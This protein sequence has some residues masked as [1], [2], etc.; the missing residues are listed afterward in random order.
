[1]SL[2]KSLAFRVVISLAG[3]VLASHTAA[4]QYSRSGSSSS[5]YATAP[6]RAPSSN[7]SAAPQNRLSSGSVYTG[8][9]VAHTTPIT[10]GSTAYK[11]V[12]YVQPS[13]SSISSAPRSTTSAPARTLPLVS[14]SGATTAVQQKSTTPSATAR[15]TTNQASQVAP[16]FHPG[17]SVVLLPGTILQG[18]S[19]AQTTPMTAPGSIP[20]ASSSRPNFGLVASRSAPTSSTGL[21]APHSSAANQSA[22]IT[23]AQS[24]QQPSRGASIGGTLL[25]ASPHTT[26]LS[27][28]P[29]F[30]TSQTTPQNVATSLPQ[31]AR[32]A[33][34]ATMGYIGES[35][36][37]AAKSAAQQTASGYRQATDPRANVVT[38]LEGSAAM[39]AG[40]INAVASPLAPIT[41]PVGSA[42]TY[43]GDKIGDNTT[44]QRFANSGPGV[45]VAR[46]TQDA[47]NLNTV[48]GAAAG[49]DNLTA[50]SRGTSAVPA[51]RAAQPVASTAGAARALIGADA[52]GQFLTTVG[53]GSGNFGLGS[54]TASDAATLGRAFVGPNARLASDG[55]TLVS[56]DGLRQY[57]PPTF[58]PN[59]GIVQAN[60][61]SRK[62]PN[63][64]WLDNGHLDVIQ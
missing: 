33:G 46:V 45:A 21:S 38:L 50:I 25:D 27:S 47:A 15:P 43:V 5:T 40:A 57:R 6:S 36:Q 10:S 13:G 64:P 23:T 58:K 34:T 20:A 30:S 41:R 35:V 42:V 2:G 60:F 11:V 54:A 9:G 32:E 48:L 4:A 14:G 49:L 62:G 16:Q 31:A 22:Q 18:T 63:G 17:T 61:E 28:R 19:A 26:Q 12:P 7:A 39:T 56:S 3:L 37:A 51:T 52:H 8:S 29:S 59:L 44:V 1:M 55:L 24:V 53:R